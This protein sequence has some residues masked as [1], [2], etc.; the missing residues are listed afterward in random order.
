MPPVIEAKVSGLAGIEEALEHAPLRVAKQIMRNALVAAGRIWKS[1]IAARVRRG[2]HH[3]DGGGKP[4][5]DVLANNVQ[6]RTH[7]SGSEVQGSVSVGF[8][9]KFYWAKFLERGTGP[10]ERWKGK[11]STRAAFRAKGAARPGGN[12]MPAFPFMAQSGQ[13]RSQDVLDR[14]TEGVQQALSEE[15]R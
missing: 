10:R 9:S 11:G 8:S 1:E 15:Y 2:P 13:A 5:Y 14:F 3:P 4:E 7:V 12:R 6:I